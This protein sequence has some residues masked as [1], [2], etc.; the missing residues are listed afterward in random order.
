[1]VIMTHARFHFNRFMLTLIFG[2]W[3]S[4]PPPPPPPPPPW[5]WQTTVK[6]GPDRVNTVISCGKKV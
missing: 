1:M 5:A 6:A 4:E 3:A 2:I